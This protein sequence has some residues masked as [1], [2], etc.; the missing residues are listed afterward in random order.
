MASRTLP[1]LI[2]LLLSMIPLAANAEL[3]RWVDDNGKTHFSDTPPNTTTPALKED[4]DDGETEQHAVNLNQRYPTQ[5]DGSNPTH[6]V[7][8]TGIQL[9]WEPQTQSERD[10]KLPVGRYFFGRGCASPTA[11]VLPDAKAMHNAL[12]PSSITLG[13]LIANN[14]RENNVAGH[15]DEAA[16]KMSAKNWPGAYRLSARVTEFELDSCADSE[17][18]SFK[19][20][21]LKDISSGRFKLH[22]LMMEFEWQLS[23]SGGKTLL[24]KRSRSRFDSWQ[25]ERTITTVYEQS[26]KALTEDFLADEQVFHLLSNNNKSSQNDKQNNKAELGWWGKIQSKGNHYMGY[27][28]QAQLSRIFPHFS[29]IKAGVIEYYMLEGRW[30]SKL[31][32]IHLD[33]SSMVDNTDGLERIYL[34]NQGS[35]ML[36][37]DTRWGP[38]AR[39]AL[40]PRYEERSSTMYWDCFT[41][42]APEDVP[43]S[44]GC[45]FE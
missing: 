29:Q 41:N 39:L 17:R 45:V 3:Y 28:R 2:I 13:G 9:L 4:Y 6:T 12:F 31:A 38:G 7:V 30:P 8:V 22:R 5:V 24:T 23:D 25:I 44:M 27:I 14:L 26:M 36:L 19:H 42:L 37:L 1:K 11:M 43:I 20:F 18:R 10:K 34:E 16:N 40:R 33:E 32:E 15:F 21:K 35:I